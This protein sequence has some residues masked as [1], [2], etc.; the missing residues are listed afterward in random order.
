MRTSPIRDKTVTQLYK[1]LLLA[2]AVIFIIAIP[3]VGIGFA[4][5]NY[6]QKINSLKEVLATTKSK[7]IDPAGGVESMPLFVK[8]LHVWESLCIDDGPCPRVT[9]GWV[10]DVRPEKERDLIED[11]FTS[12]GYQG[13]DISQYD[14]ETSGTAKS[15]SRVLQVSI[16]P[17]THEKVPVSNAQDAR[18]RVVTITV[19]E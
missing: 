12:V 4:E 10:V 3:L 11:I 15:G 18:F 16:S 17:I 2:L 7:V 1:R 19:S 8:A 5:F 9:S 6:Q 14:T 13:E